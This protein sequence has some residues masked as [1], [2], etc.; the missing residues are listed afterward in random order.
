MVQLV[1]GYIIKNDNFF[2]GKENPNQMEYSH[3]SLV[4]DKTA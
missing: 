4:T 3:N 2:G 1:T